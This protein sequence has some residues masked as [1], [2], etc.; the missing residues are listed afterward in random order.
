MLVCRGVHEEAGGAE[1]RRLERAG[2]AEEEEHLGVWGGGGRA[3]LR[4][5]EG[6]VREREGRRERLELGVVEDVFGDAGVVAAFFFFARLAFRLWRGGEWEGFTGEHETRAASLLLGDP[7]KRPDCQPNVLLALE[8]VDAQDQLLARGEL[9]LV[10]CRLVRGVGV[11]AGVDDVYRHLVLQ[12]GPGVSHDAAGEF[13][14]DGH[15]V[16]EAHAPFF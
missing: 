2:D 3:E 5:R 10:W 4:R 16:G 13:G 15:G 8:A 1:E 9:G 12:G 7:G 14:V 11:D 6:V